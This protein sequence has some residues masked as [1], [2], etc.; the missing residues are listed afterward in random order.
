ME[1]E[2]ATI[3]RM[4]KEIVAEIVKSPELCELLHGASSGTAYKPPKETRTS[5]APQTSPEPVLTD[6]E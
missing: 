2:V 5:T 6:S 3:R 1:L 4:A